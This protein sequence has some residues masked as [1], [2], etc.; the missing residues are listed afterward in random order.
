M[1]TI[2]ID[3]HYNE[4]K[5]FCG[6]LKINENKKIINWIPYNTEELAIRLVRE[7][8]IPNRPGPSRKARNA[9]S[10][11]E[12]FGEFITSE[13]IINVNDLTNS[14]IQLFAEQNPTWNYSNEYAYVKPT[15]PEEIRALLGLMFVRGVMKHNL[16]NIHKVYFQKSSNLIC[17]ATMAINRFKFSVRCVQFDDFT[18]RPKRWKSDHF[19]DF[20]EFFRCFNKNCAQL[21][22]PLEYLA[23]E[24]TISISKKNSYSSV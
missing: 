14:K 7:Q 1:K 19:A 13:M 9:K 4:N 23:I 18:T 8:I 20:R 6:K 5:H 17:K 24:E 11:E 3:F 21:R 15:T 2:M 12:H 10:I 22:T 16:R